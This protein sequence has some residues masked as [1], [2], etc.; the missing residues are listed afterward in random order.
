[1]LRYLFSHTEPYKASQKSDHE[2]KDV[3]SLPSCTTIREVASS[4]R[5]TSVDRAYLKKQYI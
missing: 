4:L 2:A 1:M 3:L 5:N